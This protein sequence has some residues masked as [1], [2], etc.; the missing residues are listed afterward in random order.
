MILLNVVIIFCTLVVGY[1]YLLYPMLI[2][3]LAKKYPVPSIIDESYQPGISIILAVHN[4]E[5]VIESC[6]AS[7]LALDYPR[8]RIE[9]LIG[10]DGS[11]DCTNEI[12]LQ[13]QAQYPYIKA[14]CFTAQR[15]KIAVLNDLIAATTSEILF[16]L[17]ADIELTPNTLRVQVRHF[18]DQKIGA[19]AGLYKIESPE[20]SVL[21]KS[22]E[23]YTSLDQQIRT[24]ESI[25]HS[26]VG[27][28]GCNYTVRRS[29]W[30][31]F[32]D[33]LIHDD[34]FILLSVLDQGFRV[35]FE[36]LSVA[37]EK[38]ARNIREEFRRKSRSASRGF[39]T[40][41]FFPE[42]MFPRSGKSALLLWSHKLLRWLSPLFM[43]IAIGLA[44]V[45]YNA[46]SGLFYQII[47]SGVVL[48]AVIVVM[49]YYAERRS[50]AIPLVRQLSWLIVMNAA[51]VA[52]AMKYLT[53]SDH[54][55][56]MSSSR[57]ESEKQ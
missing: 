28:G 10:S 2:R 5:R 49:G 1:C 20:G 39:H 45:G 24:A 52:G 55:V 23:E 19:V 57:P 15:G 47:L 22:E 4:E 36:P 56:W 11:S 21:S 6:L 35:F 44:V 32:P 31:P 37:S 53:K 13:Y 29:L 41:S 17:D 34:L 40:F 9:I 50:I 42:L 43:M 33:N 18:A 8:E 51:Y 46:T 27:L 38:F 3:L 16:C 12:L 30:K 7:L 48:A 26:S 25:Y 54:Q 14:F